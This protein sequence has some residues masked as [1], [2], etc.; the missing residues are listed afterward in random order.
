M[1]SSLLSRDYFVHTAPGG[2][3]ALVMVDRH[4]PYALALADMKMPGMSGVELL[5]Q[6]RRLSPT[7]TRVLISGLLQRQIAIDAVNQAQVFRILT[8]PCSPMELHETVAEG[9]RYYETVVAGNAEL[10]QTLDGQVKALTE[11]LSQVSPQSFRR[12]QAVRQGIR[13]LAFYFDVIN[14]WEIEVAAI[15]ARIGE[16]TLPM[17]LPAKAHNKEPLTSEEQ[18][19]WE[20]VPETGEKL[21]S[22][23]PRLAGVARDVLYQSKNF[24]GTGFPD[25]ALAGGD[26]PLGA[27]MLH[28]LTDFQL[29]IS[30]GATTETAL[31]Q[32]KAQE[33]LYDPEVLSA[34]E[35]ATAT[36]SEL[37]P[38]SARIAC[39]LR[40]LRIGHRLAEPIITSDEMLIAQ[41]GLIITGAIMDRIRAF[42]TQIGLRQPF[43]IEDTAIAAPAP[44]G[45]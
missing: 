26:I 8:K 28:V 40:D 24:D 41:R 33:G 43:F 19:S 20:H 12:A 5:T 44:Q 17:G 10:Q 42:D 1:F 13:Q 32:M 30:E 38:G 11:I 14:P 4:G 37:G 15:L 22:Y 29:A 16:V 34:L 23:I 36:W 18:K 21:I 35:L 7:T 3:E 45:T 2:P 31:A 9:I 39:R 27:R 6:V 25:D